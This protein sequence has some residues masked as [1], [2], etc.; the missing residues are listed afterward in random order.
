MIKRFIAALLLVLVLAS[1]AAADAPV[2]GE[3]RVWAGTGSPPAGW[4]LI[5]GSSMMGTTYY[6]YDY[7]QLYAAIGCT[8]GCMGD[9]MFLPNLSGRV[10]VGKD[11]GQSEF[12]TLG[13]TGGEKSH[14]LTIDE[15]PEHEWLWRL[16]K[17]MVNDDQAISLEGASE[18][19]VEAEVL[20]S[21]PG[22]L[23]VGAIDSIPTIKDF[24]EKLISEAEALR[25][26]WSI[27]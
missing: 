11:S 24:M 12:N 1:P 25:R 19:E 17:A 7:P 3:I 6:R 8:Y 26:R 10:V 4:V 15:M 16:E 5:S 22:S 2:V 20:R 13:E 23:A 14:T 21:V 18:E 27:Q 9:Y